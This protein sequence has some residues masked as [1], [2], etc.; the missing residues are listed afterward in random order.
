MPKFHIKCQNLK[1]NFQIL[2]NCQNF[3]ILQKFEKIP[4]F[5]KCQ[6]F[7]NNFQNFKNVKIS[8]KMSKFQKLQN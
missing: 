6:N 1:K 3:K 7:K 8:L 2:Q 4:K 5:R